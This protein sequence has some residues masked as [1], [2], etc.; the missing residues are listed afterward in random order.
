MCA[1][2][3]SEFFPNFLPA[4]KWLDLLD[5]MTLAQGGYFWRYMAALKL[6]TLDEPDL[7]L[8]RKALRDRY[9][10]DGGG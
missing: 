8:L 3:L 6:K 2:P 1:S 9:R 7:D 10:A 4:P 5:S